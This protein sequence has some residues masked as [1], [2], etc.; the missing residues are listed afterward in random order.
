MKEDQSYRIDL[1]NWFPICVWF[2]RVIECSWGRDKGDPF[3]KPL[4]ILSWSTQFLVPIQIGMLILFVTSM[5]GRWR[6]LSPSLR[7]FIPTRPLK[8]VVMGY[9]GGWRAMGYLTLVPT[10]L[11]WGA[12]FQW[13]FLGKPFGVFVFR[14][15]LPFLFGL[16]HGIKS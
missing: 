13:L 6:V 5:I 12:L 3:N 10:I 7:P 11:L 14:N 2:V 4:L 1:L 8:L 16:P 9:G 15:E